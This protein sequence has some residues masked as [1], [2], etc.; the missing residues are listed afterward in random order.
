MLIDADHDEAKKI[1]KRMETF[2]HL[3]SDIADT[4]YFH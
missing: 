3:L 1:M 2:A 4:F